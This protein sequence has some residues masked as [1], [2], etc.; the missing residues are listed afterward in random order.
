MGGC[1]DAEGALFFLT[2]WNEKTCCGSVLL[3]I[4]FFNV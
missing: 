3:L 2:F 4:I 1:R